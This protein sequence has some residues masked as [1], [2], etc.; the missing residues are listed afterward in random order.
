MVGGREDGDSVSQVK[1][2]IQWERGGWTA[3]QKYKNKEA[4]GVEICVYH[5]G[6]LCRHIIPVCVSINLK[7]KG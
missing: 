5:F 6:S 7:W 3:E 2:R 1:R 4:V